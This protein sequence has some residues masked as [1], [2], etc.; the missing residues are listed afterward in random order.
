M[1][2]VDTGAW[3]AAEV[4]DDQ[5][6]VKAKSFLEASRKGDYG[7]MVTTDYV[8]DE[9]ITLFRARKGLKPALDFVK[10]IKSSPKS[11]SVIWVDEFVFTEA[12]KILEDSDPH[13]WSF[14]DCTS[15]AVMTNLGIDTAFAF[16]KNF[17]ERGLTV[18]PRP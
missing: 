5:N 6:H 11:V 1:I 10:K 12:L 16:D 7:I 8:L 15:F 3:Y 18:L 4:P 14:T 13:L 17:R 2:F 9:A